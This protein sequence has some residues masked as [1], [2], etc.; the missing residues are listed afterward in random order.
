MYIC[1]ALLSS[2]VES[3]QLGP[4]VKAVYDRQ[5]Q[6][7]Y[8]TFLSANIDKKN[9]QVGARTCVRGCVHVVRIGIHVYM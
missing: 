9:A 7:T 4:A 8:Q 6:D 3:E 1:S 5:W 2:L